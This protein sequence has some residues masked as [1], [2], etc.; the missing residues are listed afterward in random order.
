LIYVG[1]SYPNDGIKSLTYSG[2]LGWGLYFVGYTMSSNAS[3]PTDGNKIGMIMTT[4]TYHECV[5]TTITSEEIYFTPPD[6]YTPADI[7]NTYTSISFTPPDGPSL[8]WYT[9][10]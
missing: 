2:W 6:V 4:N 3:M 7:T 8:G 1:L 10:T 9:T 5:E